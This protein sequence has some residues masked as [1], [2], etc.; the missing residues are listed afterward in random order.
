MK[1]YFT[2]SVILAIVSIFGI[3][4]PI[5]FRKKTELAVWLT[6]TVFFA[7]VF[8]LAVAFALCIA[9]FLI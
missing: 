6:L 8:L 7:I 4:L 5:W 1:F 2:L 3:L 9:F